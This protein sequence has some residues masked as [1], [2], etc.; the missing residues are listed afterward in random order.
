MTQ[1]SKEPRAI[2]S[3]RQRPQTNMPMVVAR[4][5]KIKPWSWVTLEV[6]LG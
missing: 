2:T 4:M 3:W 5:A 1:A 6:L